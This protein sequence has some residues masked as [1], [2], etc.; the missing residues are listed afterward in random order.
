MGWFFSANRVLQDSPSCSFFSVHSSS[1]IYAFGRCE[2]AP[3]SPSFKKQRLYKKLFI[4]YIDQQKLYHLLFDTD[5][6][7]KIPSYSPYTQVHPDT[8]SS[9]NHKYQYK[10]TKVTFFFFFKWTFCFSARDILGMPVA[11]PAFS[12]IW[13]EGRT[14][15]KDCSPISSSLLAQVYNQISY[16]PY[17]HHFTA[18][19][20]PL[21]GSDCISVPFIPYV[22]SFPAAV[23]EI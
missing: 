15:H 4:L 6:G 22:S 14:Q 7:D 21:F 12:Y 3:K 10:Q 18:F 16:H 19:H 1:D 9:D 13:M 11:L 8:F 17:K 2:T 23:R 5:L 20:L